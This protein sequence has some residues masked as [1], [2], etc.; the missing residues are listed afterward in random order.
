MDILNVHHLT[1][2]R[3]T[4]PVFFGEHRMMF[5]PRESFDQH[6]L[7]STLKITPEP[8]SIR[9]IH[10]VFGNCIGIARFHGKAKELTFE[11]VI[12]LEHSP[13]HS[14]DLPFA[15]DGGMNS[16]PFAYDAAELPDVYSSILRVY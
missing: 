8:V 12:Q 1:R 11:S 10:D 4:K 6:V 7:E 13:E 16:Y 2:F 14:L 5:R 15:P 9:Y 3:Y